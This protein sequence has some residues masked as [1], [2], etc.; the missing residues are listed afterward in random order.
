MAAEEPLRKVTE[1]KVQ[2]M[3]TRHAQHTSNS[4]HPKRLQSRAAFIVAIAICTVSVAGKVL[5]ADEPASLEFFEKD[6]RPLLVKHCYECH[7]AGDVDGGLNLDS[8]AGVARGGDSGQVIVA[9]APD[10]SL[11]VEA[12]RYQ[13]RDLQ[14]PPKGRMSDSEI[15]ILE[16]WVRLGVP[17]SRTEDRPGAVRPTG[18]SIQDGREFWSFRPVADPAVPAVQNADWVQTPIDAFVL[19]KLE[20]RKTRPAERAAKRTL[21]RRVTFDLTGLPPTPEEIAAFLADESS[22]AFEKVVER[23]RRNRASAN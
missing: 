20:T 2:L 12:V 7:S 17:D 22:D 8:K 6:V 3:L 19:T 18:M 11:L 9:G 5:V 14:M 21:I 15:A 23:Q 4:Q 13:N 16:K 10:Q 1:N